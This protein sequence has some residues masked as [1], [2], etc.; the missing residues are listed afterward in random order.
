MSDRSTPLSSWTCVSQRL[1]VDQPNC[2]FIPHL[3][4]EGKTNQRNNSNKT[5][6]PALERVK[7]S[8]IIEYTKHGDLGLPALLNSA[9]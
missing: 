1:F 9:C 7:N 4:Q 2:N 6:Y 5:R 3:Q 8:K